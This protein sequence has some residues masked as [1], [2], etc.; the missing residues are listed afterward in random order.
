MSVF[1]DPFSV[2]GLP[3]TDG[4]TGLRDDAETPDRDVTGT[5]GGEIDSLAASSVSDIE[6]F[7][8]AN[9]SDTFDGTFKPVDELVSWDSGGYDGAFCG[10]GAPGL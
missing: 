2:A 8:K 7:W 9:F 5:D 4:P 10:D 6:E 3:A 1:G